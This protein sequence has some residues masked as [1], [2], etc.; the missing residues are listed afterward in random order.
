MGL[1]LESRKKRKE[2]DCACPTLWFTAWDRAWFRGTC[3]QSAILSQG[4]GSLFVLTDTLWGRKHYCPLQSRK[5]RCIMSQVL[6]WFISGTTQIRP[7]CIWPHSPRRMWESIPKSQDG[8]RPKNLKDFL[9]PLAGFYIIILA[10]IW[11]VTWICKDHL[12]HK[13]KTAECCEKPRWISIIDKLLNLNSLYSPLSLL[14]LVSGQSH[15]S[16]T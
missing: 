4:S 15:Y 1:S 2:R 6:S 13:K 5:P 9:T 14:L 12:S 8:L 11:L 10:I 16:C 7:M 3:S